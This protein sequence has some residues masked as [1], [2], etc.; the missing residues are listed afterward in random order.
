[1]SKRIAVIA[2]QVDTPAAEVAALLTDTYRLAAE[3]AGHDVRQII[4]DELEIPS[5][6]T[7]ADWDSE[8]LPDTVRAAQDVIL[9]ADHLL[10]VHPLHH[11]A[12][13]TSLHDF[14]EQ[15][16][17]P[18]FA[19][20]MSR[21]AT[22]DRPARSARLVVTTDMPTLIYRTLMWAQGLRGW[23]QPLL[24]LVGITPVRTTLID[25]SSG[26]DSSPVQ[27]KWLPLMSHYGAQGT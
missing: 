13:P 26:V 22:L 7:L 3:R 27:R 1:M 16:F 10:L 8:P 5:L 23:L 20:D 11:G 6:R 17:R 19:L 21:R 9:W 18:A 14:V 12:M 15:V 2:V 25:G 4:V 24:K